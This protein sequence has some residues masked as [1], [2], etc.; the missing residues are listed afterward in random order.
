MIAATFTKAEAITIVVL[1]VALAALIAWCYWDDDDF[2]G[3]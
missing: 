2:M 3:R 1:V